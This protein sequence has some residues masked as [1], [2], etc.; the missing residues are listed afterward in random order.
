MCLLLYTSGTTSEPKGVRHTHNTVRAEW[1]IP[2]LTTDGP[3][4]SPF[5]AGHIAGFNFLLRPIICGIPMI[6]LDHW[7]PALAARLIEELRVKESGGTPFF[8][9]TLLEAA[10]RDSR[11][12]SSLEFFGIG[13]T[14]VTPDMVRF[15]D[16]N[17]CPAGRIYGLTEHSTVTRSD[18][19]L[20]FEKRGHT[21]GKIQPGTEILIVDEEG[22]ECPSGMDGEILIRG[23]ETFVGYHNPELDDA[24]FAPGGWF[25]TGDIGRVDAEGYL[26][27][28]DRKKDIIIR[29]GENISSREVEAVIALHPAVAETVVVAKADHQ[30]GERTCAFTILRPGLGLDLAELRRHCEEAGLARF[31]IP[32]FLEIVSDLPRT[33]AGKIRKA[34]LRAALRRTTPTETS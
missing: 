31:K 10:R 7:Y 9:Q 33:A 23:P 19:T 11:D 26:S 21:D 34:E 29:A 2:F 6:L 17:L 28:T 3:Y 27:I 12:L 24:A 30:Y 15:V 18:R 25:R 16:E 8:L 22:C 13:A 4:L 14:V 32:E 5:P 1:G 20:T